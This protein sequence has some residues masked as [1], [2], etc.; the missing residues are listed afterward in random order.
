MARLP[1]MDIRFIRRWNG[2]LAKSG[3]VASPAQR[4]IKVS[5]DEVERNVQFNK[6]TE[7]LAGNGYRR[8]LVNKE[9]SRQLK[10]SETCNKG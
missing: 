4:P 6:I 3:V 5:S 1:F 10:R 8:K 7:M 2:T 9:I